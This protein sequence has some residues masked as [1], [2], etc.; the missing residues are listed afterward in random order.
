MSH[1]GN[2]SRQTGKQPTSFAFICQQVGRRL[3]CD[4]GHPAADVA[5]DRRR[6]KEPLRGN[7]Q[8]DAHV[9]RQMHIGHDRNM[10]NIFRS[11]YSL[12]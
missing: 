3:D 9:A 6:I 5:A 11:S 2:A 10:S 12:D 1:C 7:G 8:A 4:R